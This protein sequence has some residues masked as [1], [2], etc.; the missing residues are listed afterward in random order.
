MEDSL[1]FARHKVM[2]LLYDFHAL[3]FPAQHPMK[4]RLSGDLFDGQF[5]ISEAALCSARLSPI[6]KALYI[7]HDF[8]PVGRVAAE[9]SPCDP[10][11]GVADFCLQNTISMDLEPLRDNDGN[12]LTVDLLLPPAE[13]IGSMVRAWG[14]HNAPR[15]P[16]LEAFIAHHSYVLDT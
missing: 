14:E 12:A 8:L 6:Q 2:P 4:V 10:V 5:K 13:V 1:W 15:C 11:L 3:R 9:L 7:K 16:T